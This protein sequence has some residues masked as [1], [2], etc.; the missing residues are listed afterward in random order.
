[1]DNFNY[2]G[3]ANSIGNF[4][5]LVYQEMGDFLQDN[6]T[7]LAA[8]E[9]QLNDFTDKQSSIKAYA[10]T[11]FQLS[12]SIAF[13]GAAESFK[14]IT[15]ATATLNDDIRKIEKV[16]K[17]INFSAGIINLGLAITSKNNSGIISSLQSI[18][19]AITSKLPGDATAS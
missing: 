3:F 1:M 14:K 16:D 9:E 4:Y 7:T 18:K 10:N 12:D 11:F 2:A 5:Q 6:I 8:N 17:W 15:A 13:A 19:T